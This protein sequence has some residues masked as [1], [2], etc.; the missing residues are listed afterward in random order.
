MASFNCILFKDKINRRLLPH[1]PLLLILREV[2][3]LSP[4]CKAESLRGWT[5]TLTLCK[6][7]DTFGVRKATEYP[8]NAL[9]AYIPQNDFS[10]LSPTPW[11]TE[12]KPGLTRLQG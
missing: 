8:L 9:R 11:C 4:H 6:A 3:W 7:R 1:S 5:H 2:V 10:P 12:S